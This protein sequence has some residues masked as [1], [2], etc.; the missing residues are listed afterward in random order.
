MCPPSSHQTGKQTSHGASNGAF[1]RLQGF[2][3]NVRLRELGGI[4]AM[5]ECHPRPSGEKRPPLLFPEKLASGTM[6]KC[7]GGGIIRR[8]GNIRTVTA[9]STIAG[10]DSEFHD[11]SSG[12][13]LF[14]RWQFMRFIHLPDEAIP[15]SGNSF[16]GVRLDGESPSAPGSLLITAFRPCSKSPKLPPGHNFS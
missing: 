11:L 15:S 3:L 8:D 16:D 2:H 13:H 5:D 9:A 1:F 12:M 10:Y 4:V 7:R 14:L 6:S